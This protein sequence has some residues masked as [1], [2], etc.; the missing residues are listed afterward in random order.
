MDES[1]EHSICIQWNN[2]QTFLKGN[3]DIFY[4][5]NDTGKHYAE[6][7]KDTWYDSTY[8]RYFELST[9]WT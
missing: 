5:T 2:I 3:S 8:I 9:Q 6:E 4:N 1:I 7:N